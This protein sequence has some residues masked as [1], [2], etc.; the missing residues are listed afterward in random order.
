V[1]SDEERKAE[2]CENERQAQPARPQSLMQVTRD[3]I[4]G[5]LTF[6]IETG[7]SSAWARNAGRSRSD[8]KP[9]CTVNGEIA[10]SSDASTGFGL[11][12]WLRITMRPP[13]RQTRRISRATVTGSGTTL[14]K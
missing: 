12:K 2:E 9:M 3:Q 8:L 7:L 4:R 6:S 11:R 13:G 1:E 14:I 5:T 10:R